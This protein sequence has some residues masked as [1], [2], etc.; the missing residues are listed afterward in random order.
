[1]KTNSTKVRVTAFTRKTDVLYFTY[2]LLDSPITLTDII[3][4]LGI[5]WIQNC[6]S[7]HIETIFSPNPEECWAEY[8]LKPIPF[9]LLIVY[10]YFTET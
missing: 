3:K 9:Q 6:I 8:E 7:A 10:Y 1:M 2:K 5:N 4:D